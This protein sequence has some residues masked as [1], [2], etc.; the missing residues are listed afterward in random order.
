[1]PQSS[2]AQGSLSNS[3]KYANIAAHSN[4]GH[5]YCFRLAAKTARC[6]KEAA[7]KQRQNGVERLCQQMLIPFDERAGSLFGA[8]AA[9]TLPLIYSFSARRPIITQKC[10]EYL[11]E[12]AP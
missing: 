10:H 11:K 12:W 2:V 6:P 3:Q 7:Q 4:C 8:A 9:T 1:M 5:F